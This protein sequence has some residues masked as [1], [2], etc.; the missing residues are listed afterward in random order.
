MYIVISCFVLA[1]A[2]I[3]LCYTLISVRPKYMPLLTSPD[4]PL[5]KQ[6][7]EDAK[8]SLDRFFGLFEKYPKDALIKLYFESNTDQVEYL[9]AEVLE[10]PSEKSDELKVRLVTPPVTH[11]GKFDR[12][13]MCKTDDIRD[14][15]IKDDQNNIYGGF[16]ERAMFKIAERDKVTLPKKLLERKMRYKEV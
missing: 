16:T 2:G 10:D 14:W 6:A 5:M 9:W 3:A 13:Y 11:R 12:V 15:A 7:A 8:A 4:D 1:I